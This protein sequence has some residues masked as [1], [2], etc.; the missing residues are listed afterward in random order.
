MIVNINLT[1]AASN[2]AHNQLISEIRDDV[3]IAN[4]SDGLKY[5]DKAQKLFN[6]LYDA[7]YEQLEQSV[8]T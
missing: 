7:V 3:W 8:I 1:E 4:E 2:I 5:T 6:E